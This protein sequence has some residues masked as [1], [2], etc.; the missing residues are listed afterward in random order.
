MNKL[1]VLC[2]ADIVTGG[3]E[4][5]H[6]LV[7]AAR[8]LGVDASI[9]YAPYRAEVN[10]AYSHYDVAVTA[11]LPDQYGTVVVASEVA[12]PFI[13]T[14]PTKAQWVLWW[15]SVDNFF[16]SLGSTVTARR[17]DPQQLKWLCSSQSGVIHLTQSQYA[18]S[19]LFERQ[20]K[21][22][23][24]TDYLSDAFVRDAI[25]RQQQPKKDLVLYNPRKGMAF[26]QQLIDASRG[27]LEFVPIEGLD[28]A[29][30]AELLGSAKLYID[31]GQHPG[32]DRLPREAALSGCCVITG[33]RG[34]AGNAVDMPIPERF[35]LDDADP[36]VVAD[37]TSL[38][39][40]VMHDFDDVTGEFDDY[41]RIIG[42]Q[43][44]TFVEETASFLREA[45]RP[46]MQGFQRGNGSGGGK[47]RRK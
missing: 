14:Q 18:R 4:A 11:P 10:P 43:H 13:P 25:D 29:G 21:S 24:L 3:P 6:Q 27:E 5:L 17:D 31:F 41:R 40:S 47:K 15:L 32:R 16:A 33:R 36:N 44:E 1:I 39:L 37:F 2:P 35:R 19:F 38:A 30:V 26:T 9:L 42:T 23:M 7:A 28:A 34:A 45:S 22:L 8:G 12:L 20:V 46:R